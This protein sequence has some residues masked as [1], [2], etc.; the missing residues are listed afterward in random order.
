[1]FEIS[2]CEHLTKEKL[3][4]KIDF[5]SECI[6]KGCNILCSCFLVTDRGRQQAD[7]TREDITSQVCR[8]S[9]DSRT[10]TML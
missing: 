2:S 7:W 8:T 3:H 6:N 1:M 4:H 9:T 10:V 5:M